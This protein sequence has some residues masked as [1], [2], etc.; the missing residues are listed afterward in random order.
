M[1]EGVL[2]AGIGCDHPPVQVHVGG[3]RMTGGRG[4]GVSRQTAVRALAEA[5][6][7]CPHYRPDTEF[8][9]LDWNA[10]P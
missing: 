1:P 9:V 4:S 8:S 7:A 10:L 3:C 5:A 2:E 6:E